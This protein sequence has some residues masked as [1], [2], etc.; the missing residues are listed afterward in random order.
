MNDLRQYEIDRQHR[1]H[2]QQQASRQPATEQSPPAILKSAR[3]RIGQ[4]LDSTPA[5]P[6]QPATKR[7]T[8]T[9][10]SV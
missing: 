7:T 10:P 4:M 8:Q 1:Q 6:Q 2:L 3:R 5:Q 9:V